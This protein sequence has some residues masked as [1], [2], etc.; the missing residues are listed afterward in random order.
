[1]IISTQPDIVYVNVS[2]SIRDLY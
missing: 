2:A 1:M